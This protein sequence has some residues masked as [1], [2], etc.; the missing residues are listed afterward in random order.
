MSTAASRKLLQ[1]EG[2]G[3]GPQLPHMFPMHTVLMGRIQ[4]AAEDMFKVGHGAVR[5]GLSEGI[6]RRKMLEWT[7]LLAL[8]KLEVG[9][10]F[11]WE[12]TLRL[13]SNGGQLVRP[14]LCL[15]ISSNSLALHAKLL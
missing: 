5:R 3:V 13:V 10:A 1:L 2:D 15:G 8:D 4:M 11:H 6:H 12:Q 7:N 14:T 9:F